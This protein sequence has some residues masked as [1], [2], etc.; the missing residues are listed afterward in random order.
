[1]DSG[2]EQIRAY[3]TD[4]FVTVVWK[5]SQKVRDTVEE[6]P[7]S[8]IYGWIAVCVQ[9]KTLSYQEKKLY[10]A[11]FS[12]AAS[13]CT[14]T[15]WFFGN[16]TTNFQ[17]LSCI[18]SNAR[19]RRE[20]SDCSLIAPPTQSRPQHHLSVHW[21]PELFRNETNYEY[22]FC[23]NDELERTTK[24]TVAVYFKALASR[25]YRDS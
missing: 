14:E 24:E 18:A 1:M 8:S 21:R 13:I 23:G 3:N 12:S 10:D 9:Q 6:L 4:I 17:L 16:L 2:K 20:G 22:E 5:E 19:D 15:D 11:W 25:D 7:Q